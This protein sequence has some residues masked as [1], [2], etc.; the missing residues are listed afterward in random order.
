MKEKRNSVVVFTAFFISAE[1]A[2]LLITQPPQLR[3]TIVECLT[4]RLCEPSITFFIFGKEVYFLLFLV[5]MKSIPATITQVA[6]VV[7]FLR[8]EKSRS[9]NT[10]CCLLG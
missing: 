7:V 4:T 2:E 9:A 5:L 10:G 3:L 1:T 6:A 8:T